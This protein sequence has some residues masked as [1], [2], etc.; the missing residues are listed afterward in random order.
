MGEGTGVEGGQA[1]PGLVHCFYASECCL[2]H[3]FRA[4][5]VPVIPLP[6]P[7]HTAARP[8]YCYPLSGP[9]AGPGRRRFHCRVTRQHGPGAAASRG[10]E[11]RSRLRVTVST[12][13][14]W[15]V[16]KFNGFA[17]LSRTRFN[18]STV[19][20]RPP[21]GP[22]R[23]GMLVKS[24]KNP[25]SL[26]PLNH[27]VRR[28]ITITAGRRVWTHSGWHRDRPRLGEPADSDGPVPDALKLYWQQDLAV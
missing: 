6:R 15:K 4:G 10:A 2:R 18:G 19:R 28:C 23:H 13:S 7:S 8:G 17:K 24:A 5:T 22:A 16:R 14:R 20:R 21:G 27:E 26:K 9:R 12:A 11:R 25:N 1:G 3:L